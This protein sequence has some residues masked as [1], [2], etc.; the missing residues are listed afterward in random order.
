MINEENSVKYSVCFIVVAWM[1][2]LYIVNVENV[3]FGQVSTLPLPSI[4]KLPAVK[5]T[6]PD[7]GENVT[8]GNPLSVNGI[9]SDDALTNCQVSLIVNNMKPYQQV[10]A[11]GTAVNN[12]YST[13]N[14]MLTENYTKLREGTNKLTSKIVCID[15]MMNSTKWYSVNVTGHHSNTKSPI[16]GNTED[17]IITTTNSNTLIANVRPASNNSKSI[18]PQSPIQVDNN[19]NLLVPSQIRSDSSSTPSSIQSP[20]SNNS[21]VPVANAGPDQTVSAGSTVTL[22]GGRSNDLDGKITSYSWIQTSGLPTIAL[23]NADSSIAKVQLPDVKTNT[24]LKFKLI[25]IDNDSLSRSDLTNILV[26]PLSHDEDDNEVTSEDVP[27]EKIGIT[28]FC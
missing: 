22:N 8:I 23:Q 3:T 28:N 14:Y 15:N 1:L 26:K 16:D 9:S 21:R 12:D 4:S 20:L 11:N 5:I 18:L 19:T 27:C 10:S 17:T 7:N 2:I 24:N 25:V 13:W 6:S